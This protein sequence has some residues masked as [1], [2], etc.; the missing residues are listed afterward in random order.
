[1]AVYSK[2][3]AI[4]TAHMVLNLT[5]VGLFA[6]AAILMVDNG[7]TDGQRLTA[8]IA[9]HAAGVIALS[10]SGWLGGEMV[11]RHHLGVIADSQELEN[12]EYDRHKVEAGR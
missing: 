2:A 4:A 7:A 10:I 9:L 1:M 12:A 8:V 3:R 6:A 5:T 11:F